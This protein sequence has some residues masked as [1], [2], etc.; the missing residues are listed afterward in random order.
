MEFSFSSNYSAAL[1]VGSAY[2]L[3]I[4]K[5]L[6]QKIIKKGLHGH[7]SYNFEIKIL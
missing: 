5:K 2:G 6:N 3:K 4:I 7:D 1:V